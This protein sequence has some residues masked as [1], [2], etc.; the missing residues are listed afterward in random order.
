M[1]F[2]ACFSENI[3]NPGPCSSGAGASSS[4]VAMAVARGRKHGEGNW[5]R[6]LLDHDYNGR[7]GVMLRDSWRILK[8]D[9]V[10]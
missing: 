10:A 8:R 9:T 7:T 3:F 1:Y 5:K 2:V 4:S 6:M